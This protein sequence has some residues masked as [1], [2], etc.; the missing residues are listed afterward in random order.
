MTGSSTSR[1][2][3]FPYFESLST[4]LEFEACIPQHVSRP[5]IPCLRT[6]DVVIYRSPAHPA[7]RQESA[8]NHAE[9]PRIAR[10]N[11]FDVFL[12][13]RPAVSAPFPRPR[14]I[15]N[16]QFE[17]N[18]QAG[19][20]SPPASE[21]PMLPEIFNPLYLWL[22]EEGMRVPVA[23]VQKFGPSDLPRALTV[24]GSHSLQ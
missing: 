21:P 9:P 18:L 12:E 5:V 6:R 4:T 8:A 1:A 22:V 10:P 16:I 24:R 11:A 17:A 19:S 23:H 14:L 20:P 2:E 3:T 13:N 15:F 7:R